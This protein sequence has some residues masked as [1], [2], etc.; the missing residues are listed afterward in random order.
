MKAPT[1][2]ILTKI[3]FIGV[4]GLYNQSDN[5]EGLS[6]MH[7]LKLSA[8]QHNLIEKLYYAD[9]VFTKADFNDPKKAVPLLSGLHEMKLI[10][11]KQVGEWEIIISEKGNAYYKFCLEQKIKDASEERKHQETIRQ[12]KRQNMIAILALIVSAISMVTSILIPLL[13]HYLQK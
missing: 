12:S 9:H 4:F 1:N 2:K 5:A 11:W 13:L 10:E 8:A 6:F 7:N 3:T